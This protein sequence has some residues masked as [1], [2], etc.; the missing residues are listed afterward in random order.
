ML[1]LRRALR[2]VFLALAAVVVFVEEFGWRPLSRL[3]GQL[4][5]WPPIGRLEARIRRLPPRAAL[6]LFGVPSVLLFPLKLA[7]LALANA[8]HAALGIGLI[9]A[10]KV[11]GTAIV[12]RLFVLLEP[13]LRTFA[14]FAR[15]LDTWIGFKARVKAWWRASAVAR[16][17]QALR[18]GWRVWRRRTFRT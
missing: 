11:V 10:A 14:W 3:V 15:A 2:A 13:Q 5:R 7:A 9:I 18:A 16:R 6:V 1:T 17:L 4:A 12:G 8:G